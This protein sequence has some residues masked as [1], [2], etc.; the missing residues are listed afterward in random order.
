MEENSHGLNEVLSQMPEG[1][2]ET[3]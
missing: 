3:C 1:T 2:E